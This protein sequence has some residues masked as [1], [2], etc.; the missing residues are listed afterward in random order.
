MQMQRKCTLYLELIYMFHPYA[1]SA[2]QRAGFSH[3]LPFLAGHVFDQALVGFVSFGLISKKLQFSFLSTTQVDF[4][5]VGEERR[6]FSYFTPPY[7][8]SLVSQL[9]YLMSLAF[10]C[11][12]FLSLS[13]Q[14]FSTMLL[15]R[16][17]PPPPVSVASPLGQAWLLIDLSLLDLSS[18]I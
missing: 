10:I 3:V 6:E 14:R 8:F 18:S 4:P 2:Y 17:F 16:L 12:H 9:I 5:Q 11:Y 15:C 13:Y 1:H 7:A